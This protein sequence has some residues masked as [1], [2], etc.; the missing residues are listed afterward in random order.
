LILALD[1]EQTVWNKGS[2]F[3]QR[4]FNVCVSYAYRREDGELVSRTVFPEEY[5][6]VRALVHGATTLVFFNAKYDLHWLRK[7][8][9][10]YRDKRIWCCQVFEFL[11]SRQSRPFPSLEDSCARHGLGSKVDVIARDYWGRGINTHEIPRDVLAD[12]ATQDAKLTLLLFE[13]QRVEQK[14]RQAVLFSVSMQDLVV[15]AD[16]EWNGMM[17]NKKKSL[18]KAKELEQE[19]KA[20][21]EQLS[22]HHSVPNFNWSSSDHLSALLYGGEITETVK[23]PIGFYKTGAKAGQVR[24]KNEEKIYH[25]P[26]KY[27]PIKG[28]ELQKENKWSVEEQYLRRLKGDE[29]L[30]TGI[31]RIKELEKLKNTYYEGLP[32]LHD[33]MFWED[34]IIHGSFN[35]C[36]ARTGRL[37]SSKPNLQNLSELAQELFESR[38]TNVT[39]STSS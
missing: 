11:Y 25:L 5:A 9:I 32:H 1:T 23:V 15:L 28:S 26:R 22:L 3:D 39:H 17:Y 14:P 35:L 10:E 38:W 2:P 33:E 30:I 7:L 8:G 36:I 21:Q 29:A 24:Y 27:T 12:Y 18:E 16:M 31:L 37:S 19:I 20:I 13:S 6:E 4:N 34:S